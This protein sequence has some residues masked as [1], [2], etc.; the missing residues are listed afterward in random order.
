MK[1]RNKFYDKNNLKA[2]IKVIGD[3][4]N[5]EILTRHSEEVANEIEEVINKLVIKHHLEDSK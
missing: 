3:L 5:V 4:I 2:D 1:N